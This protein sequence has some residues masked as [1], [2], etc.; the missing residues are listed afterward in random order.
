M[1]FFFYF[2]STSK[3]RANFKSTMI[4]FFCN[5]DKNLYLVCKTKT[6]VKQ[7]EILEFL[8][9]FYLVKYYYANILLDY[10]SCTFLTI[11]IYYIRSFFL[12]TF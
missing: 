2:T 11:F 12:K 6:F 10:V 4:V 1:D 5:I 7:S 3:V 8:G 9:K